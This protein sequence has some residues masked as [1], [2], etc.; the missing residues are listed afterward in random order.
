MLQ[1]HNTTLFTPDTVRENANITI[2]DG[3]FSQILDA[4]PDSL[5]ED[6]QTI[7]GRGLL[8]VPGFIDL[9]LN[10]AFGHDFTADP[11]TIWDVSARLPRYGVTA[12]LQ[13]I[14]TTPP[15][16]NARA[17]GVLRDGPP[18]EYHGAEP[19]G[20]HLEGPFLNPGKKGAHNPAYLLEPDERMTANWSPA[21]GVRLVTL[22]PEL[23]GAAALIEELASRGVVVSAGHSSATYAEAEAGF[24]AGVRYG[25]HLFNAMSP[26]D[27]REPGLP[28]ALL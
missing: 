7:D 4:A 20:L 25:T 24:A 5:P 1:I 26:L 13:T 18:E 17:Q 15:D 22:A 27:H 2:R 16:K 9:Q 10:G 6:T 12:F 3:R 19:L 21:A 11:G 23:P 8:A 14:I 28:G